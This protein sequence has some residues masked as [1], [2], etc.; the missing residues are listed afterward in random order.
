ME[1]TLHPRTFWRQG[2]I[3]DHSKDQ[4]QI[5]IHT[6][7]LYRQHVYEQLL[8][9]NEIATFLLLFSKIIMVIKF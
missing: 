4:V 9:Y 1:V 2:V 6:S 5:I 8:F 7:Q 3:N